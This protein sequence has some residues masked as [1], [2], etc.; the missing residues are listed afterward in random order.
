MH[1]DD[2]GSAYEHNTGIAIVRRFE[3]R[4]DASAV[5]AVLVA[6]H[7]PFCWGKTAAEAAQNAVILEE[8]ARM[9]YQTLTINGGASPIRRALHDRHFLRKHGKDAYYGQS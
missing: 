2:V 4:M 7:G 1:D 6:G 3:G 5:P 8:V 9:A